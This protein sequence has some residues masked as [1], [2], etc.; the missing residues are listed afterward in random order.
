MRPSR[1]RKSRFRSAFRESPRSS[2]PQTAAPC[3][4]SASCSVRA[5]SSL[6]VPLSPV[7]STETFEGAIC[8]ISRKIS[9]MALEL[10]TSAPS[11]PV[12]RSRRRATSSSISVS[13]CRVALARIVR[14]RVASTGFCRKSYAPSFIASTAS[15]M[16]PIAVSTTTATFELRPEPVL[17][18]LGQQ[19][20]AVHARHLQVGHHDGRIP[21]QRLLPALDAVARGL[22]AVSPSGDQLRQAHQRMRLVFDN[23]N[24]DRILHSAP[25]A[26]GVGKAF[27]FQAAGKAPK[28]QR[29]LCT[30]VLAQRFTINRCCHPQRTGPQMPFSSGASADRSSPA[31][32]RLGVVNRRICFCT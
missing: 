28:P 18:Q 27:V 23:Q 2:P 1:A 17:G 31:G 14:S 30:S 16:D 19:A 22:G 13:R 4:G 29:S 10:P 25:D 20:N 5:T 15:S 26:T 9:R 7:M 32:W 8:S 12:S 21:G 24:F 3:A 11:T 6:P